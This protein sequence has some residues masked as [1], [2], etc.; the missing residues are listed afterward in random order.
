MASEIVE[1]WKALQK[2]PLVPKPAESKPPTYDV[3]GTQSLAERPT[4]VRRKL[5]PQQMGELY[6]GLVSKRPEL[7]NRLAE[8]G[9]TFYT[10]PLLEQRENMGGKWSPSTKEVTVQSGAEALVAGHEVTHAALS[11]SPIN[12]ARFL[13]DKRYRAARSAD[14]V[15]GGGIVGTALALYLA[16]AH[17]NAPEGEVARRV[18]SASYQSEVFAMGA[19][20]AGAYPELPVDY[21]EAKRLF[22]GTFDPRGRAQ[23]A[24]PWFKRRYPGR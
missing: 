1:K 2:R 23:T 16:A 5:T 15:V 4:L 7:L 14:I 8:R 12:P 17:R 21:S 11:T 10:D 6:P 13:T 9:V 20:G 24:S 22:G 3:K 19:G 18:W